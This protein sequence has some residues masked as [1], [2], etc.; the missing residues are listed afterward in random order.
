MNI[1]L[2]ILLVIVI[3]VAVLLLAALILKKEYAIERE[4]TIKQNKRVVFD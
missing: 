1:L 4:I 2:K 3:I